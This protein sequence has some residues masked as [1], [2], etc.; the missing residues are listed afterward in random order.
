MDVKFNEVSRK[1]VKLVEVSFS[2]KMVYIVLP[3]DDV[4]DFVVVDP[5]SG[6]TNGRSFGTY[7]D[8][9]CYAAAFVT[10]SYY[11]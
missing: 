8:A 3:H 7:D 11:D 9:S 2:T 6:D 4:T 5:Y 10:G 1:G